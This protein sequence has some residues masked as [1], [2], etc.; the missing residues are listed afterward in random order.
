MTGQDN[1]MDFEIGLGRPFYEG[2]VHFSP[3]RENTTGSSIS[4]DILK[5]D[6]DIHSMGADVYFKLK[7]G[8]QIAAELHSDGQKNPEPYKR[9]CRYVRILKNG[10]GPPLH[11]R[12]VCSDTV[13]SLHT[14]RPCNGGLRPFSGILTYLRDIFVFSKKSEE[15]IRHIRKVLTAVKMP[16]APLTQ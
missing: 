14:P 7:F 12:G 15:H 2:D 10:R 6:A 4:L 3:M 5:K 13:V 11:G 16:K 1:S 9:R 8:R